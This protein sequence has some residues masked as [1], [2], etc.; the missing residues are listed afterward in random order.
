MTIALIGGSLYDGVRSEL[1]SGMTVVID[2]DR[3]VAVGSTAETAFPDDAIEVDVRGRTILPGL[4]DLHSHCT[5]QYHF[6]GAGNRSF[7]SPHS[8]MH[9]ALAAIPRL[10]QALSAGQTTMR[11]CGSIGDTAFELRNAIEAGYVEGPRLHVAG[12][13]VES[14][15]GPHPH[16]PRSICAADGEEAVRK[17]VWKQIDRGADFIKVAINDTE[18]TQSELRAAVEEAHQSGRKV[19]CHVFQASSTKLAISAGV[20]SLEHARFLD[21]EDVRAMADSGIAWVA[22]VSGIRDK[23][24][25]GEAFLRR[26]SLAPA[27]RAEVRAT[28]DASRPIVDAQRATV[29]RALDAGVMIGAGTDRTG[30]YGPDP[31]ADLARELEVLVDLGVPTHGALSAATGTAAAIVGEADIGVISP[32]RRADLVVVNGNPLVDIRSVAKVVS[33]IKGGVFVGSVDDQAL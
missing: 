12:Q 20:D 8:D 13:I 1:Q 14:V 6:D 30:A 31:F 33:V 28:L 17:A 15:A 23:F 21:A 27:L 5:W 11:D 16:E 2:G 3:I 32:G 26:P 7:R 18:W 19:A 4:I 24:P 25:L 29:E 22:A 9:L 10:Q